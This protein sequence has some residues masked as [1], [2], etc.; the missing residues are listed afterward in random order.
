MFPTMNLSR[1]HRIP[2][3]VIE[4]SRVEFQ[5]WL[6]SVESSLSL[7]K[8]NRPCFVTS[9]SNS[10]RSFPCLPKV[11]LDSTKLR[12]EFESSFRPKILN[13]MYQ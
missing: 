1:Q 11:K 7:I 3:V 12:V 5:G 4:S 2:R 10:I 6:A 8:L 9:N 13:S